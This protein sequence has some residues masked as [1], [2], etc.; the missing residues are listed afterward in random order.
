MCNFKKFYF[1]FLKNTL[2]FRSSIITIIFLSLTVVEKKK[3]SFPCKIKESWASPMKKIC[4]LFLL[5]RI[6]INFFH[7]RCAYYL[8][9]CTKAERFVKCIC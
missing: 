5:F 4:V 3:P 8:I 2:T 9:V 6:L 7:L 1:R